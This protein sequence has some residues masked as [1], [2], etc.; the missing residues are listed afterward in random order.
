[1]DKLA[2]Q[3]EKRQKIIVGL[4]GGLSSYIAAYLLKIQKFDLIGVTILQQINQETKC[5][6]SAE[7]LAEIKDFCQRLNIGHVVIDASDEFSEKVQNE[8]ISRRLELKAGFSCLSCHEFRLKLLYSKMLELGADFISTGHFAKIFKTEHEITI[9]SVH[10]LNL[11]QSQILQRLDKRILNSLV[12][13]LGS[14]GTSEISKLAQNFSLNS[15]KKQ[16][17]ACFEGPESLDI[18]S[19][20]S[21]FDKAGE[22]VNENGVKLGFHKG[23]TQVLPGQELNFNGTKYLISSKVRNS[24]HILATKTSYFMRKTIR[25]TAV[26]WAEGEESYTPLNAFMNTVNG[27]FKVKVYPKTL[28]SVLVEL[29]E[30]ME[31]REYQILSLYNKKGGNSKLILSGMIRFPQI[32]L[33]S[34]ED[35]W[36]AFF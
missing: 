5:A 20:F 23:V 31:L 4:S 35:D 12:L 11:D 33:G 34:R 14:L 36:E 18:L 28:E 15:T 26:Q 25:L 9:H 13:P 7:T 22:F 16:V 21:V 29:P 19:R 3:K 24:S 10:D 32:G 17:S 30:E 6:V 2:D 8:W 27:C 1:M